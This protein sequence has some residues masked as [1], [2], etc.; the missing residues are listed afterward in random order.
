MKKGDYKAITF[1]VPLLSLSFI[2]AAFIGSVLIHSEIPFLLIIGSI[3]MAISFFICLFIAFSCLYYFHK[4]GTGKCYS[5]GK[6]LKGRGR[7]A[8]NFMLI[9][10]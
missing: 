10:P 5:C 4:I 8:L 2:S 9:P 6:V 3:L 1:N 7:K